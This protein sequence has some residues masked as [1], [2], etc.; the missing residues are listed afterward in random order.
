[1]NEEAMI[2]KALRMGARWKCRACGWARKEPATK[3][4]MEGAARGEFKQMCGKC[5]RES[6]AWV[7]APS[8]GGEPKVKVD[9]NP[10]KGMFEWEQGWG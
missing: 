6:G 3:E 5:S 1:L 4:E 9:P 10:Y 2:Q 8:D 7:L